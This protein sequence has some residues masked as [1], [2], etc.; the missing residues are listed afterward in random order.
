VPP[1]VINPGRDVPIHLWL[2]S[3]GPR[4]TDTEPLV[5]LSPK[6]HPT[7]SYIKQLRLALAKAFPGV[8]FAFLPSDMTTQIL[9]FGLPAPID[10]QVIGHDLEG[11][12]VWA[13]QVLE[14]MRSVP[15][16]VDLRVQQPFDQPYLHMAIERTK[17]QELGFSAHDIAQNLLYP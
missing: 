2:Q 5:T 8:T 15:G 4:D 13:D 11:D 12:C 3:P 14:K 9:N 17:A 16:A 6:H 1:Y 7:E 10:I